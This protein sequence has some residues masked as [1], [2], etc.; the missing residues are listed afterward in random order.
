[1][2]FMHQQ[3]RIYNIIT[4]NCTKSE[5]GY[6]LVHLFKGCR[7][8]CC[9]DSQYYHDPTL[10]MKAKTEPSNG[11]TIATPISDCNTTEGSISSTTPYP[12]HTQIK[13][14]STMATNSR[15][16]GANLPTAIATTEPSNG[17]TIAILS[18]IV[19]TCSHVLAGTTFPIM[20]IT[21]VM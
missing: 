13:N 2:I 20:I 14:S 19:A 21:R 16:L 12:T 8:E 10:I 5:I 18:M 17:T 9:D 3:I 1:M 11:T 7:D 4:T 15:T 6:E